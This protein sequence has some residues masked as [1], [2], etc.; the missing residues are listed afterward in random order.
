[1]HCCNGQEMAF[2]GVLG[3]LARGLQRTPQI[4]MA[5]QVI[6]GPVTK[7]LPAAGRR[8]G[9]SRVAPNLLAFRDFVRAL[10][11]EPAPVFVVGAM[12][13][14]QLEAAYV[15]E[16]VALSEFPLSA[17]C[18]LGRITNALEDKWGVV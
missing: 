4:S 18:C 15:D 14:G 9:F 17:A 12:A 5:R 7:H 2:A 13:H 1:M 3:V 10:P 8:V 11:D 16:W 6:K